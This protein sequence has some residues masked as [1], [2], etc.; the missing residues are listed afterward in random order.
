MSRFFYLHLAISNLKKNSKT[1]IPYIFTSVLCTM[2][3]YMVSSLSSN[4]DMHQMLGG[5]SIASMLGFGSGVIAIFAIIFL[6]YTYSFLIKRRKKEFGLFN[7]LGLEK[8]HIARVVAYESLFCLIA[9]LIFGLGLGILLDKAFFMLISNMLDADIPLGFYVSKKVIG[10]SILLF[11]GIYSL[12]YIF[13][14]L[15]I[16]MNNPIALLQSEKVGE[17]EPKSKWF[18]A[19]IGVLCL[20]TGYF[21]SVTIKDPVSAIFLFFVAV[22]L[23]IVG[24]YLLFTCI[25]IV[26]L[27][28]LRKNKN[29]YY[30][31]NH[32]ISISNMI[33]RMKQN[34]VGL[35]NICILST[36]VLV[37]LSTTIS[38]WVGVNSSVEL[39]YPKD[40][41]IYSYSKKAEGLKEQFD[42]VI[43]SLD[44]QAK[45]VL[46]TIELGFSAVRHENTF[47]TGAG[48]SSVSDINKLHMLKF[49]PLENYNQMAHAHETLQSQEVLVYASKTEYTFNDLHIF[50]DTYKVKK[51]LKEYVPDGDL[52]AQVNPSLIVVVKDLSDLD[53][54]YKQ[55][56]K[57]Y[58]EYCSDITLRYGFNTDK[59]VDDEKL[60]GSI[61]YK[62]LENPVLS[63]SRAEIKDIEYKGLLSLYVGFLF[64]GI[65]LSLL[66]V[67]ATILIMY[68]KQITEGYQDRK[69]FEIMQ[70]VGLDR[71]DIKRAINSQVLTVFFM[72]LVVAGIHVAFAFPIISKLMKLMMLDDM[73]LYVM[74]TVV[75]FILFASLYVLVYFVTSKV[76]YRI[77]LKDE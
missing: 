76:Y 56:E 34:A 4:P 73:K 74:T 54:I 53:K 70:N 22:V 25:S 75:C 36:M 66:F 63:H 32:F 17:K 62:L 59:N 6:F 13:T 50:G 43:Q 51:H 31:T 45:D 16:K 46:E 23:V 55:Q 3:F 19:L 29:Y 65:F 64:I 20:S 69:R 52:A 68:Y 57:V 7:I 5:D 42:S 49:I 12:I 15:Q 2:M 48:L 60:T 40:I 8:K 1:I 61:M 30:K 77:V 24:T 9:S 35:A 71:K 67:M 58:G 72:P 10:L 26:V 41:M 14:M 47:E 11:V 18:L 38:L 37:M 28:L 21:I 44:L 39:R 27:K 33:Y